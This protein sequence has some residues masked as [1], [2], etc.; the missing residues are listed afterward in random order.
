VAGNY[1][2]CGALNQWGLS[3]G[4]RPAVSGHNSC[5]TWWPVDFAPE[6]VVGVGVSRER[7]ERTFETVELVTMHRHPLA[8]PYEGELPIWLCRGWKVPPAQ[9]REEAR[10]A[11]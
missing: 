10:F 1:G 8:M 7:L 11:I 9:A 4:L 6:I 2:E 3:E 5:W